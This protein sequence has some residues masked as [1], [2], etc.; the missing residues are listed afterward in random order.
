MLYSGVEVRNSLGVQYNKI[1]KTRGLFPSVPSKQI[2]AEA[3]QLGGNNRIFLAKTESSRAGTK[4][5][6]NHNKALVG[7]R[8]CPVPR[9]RNNRGD[10]YRWQAKHIQSSHSKELICEGKIK[11]DIL[12]VLE[13]MNVVFC[14]ECKR[15]KA[16][17]HDKGVCLKCLM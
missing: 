5:C 17:A 14:N 15:I 3:F 2:E 10:G 13:E 7:N 11:E 9:C 1:R 12:K 4:S 6:R 8:N 16:L